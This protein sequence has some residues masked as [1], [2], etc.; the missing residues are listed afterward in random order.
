[1]LHVHATI[2]KE[3]GMLA[4][5]NSPQKHKDVILYLLEGE[6]LLTQ[7]AIVHW[8]GHQRNGGFVSQG[9][10]KA[11]ETAKQGSGLQKSE[12]VMALLIALL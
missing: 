2:C 3:G 11:D 12:Q 1:M 8:R 5:G 9:N 4:A 10:I 6:Q 7:A